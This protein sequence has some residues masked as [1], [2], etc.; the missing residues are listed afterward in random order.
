MRPSATAST[1]AEL[2]QAAR[3]GDHHAFA[4]LL[5]RYD[6]RMR[7]LAY[8]LL[9]DRSKMDDV[10][11]ESYLKAYRALGRFK[12]GSEFGTWLYK[13]TYNTCIDELRR[14]RRAPVG[15]AEIE[16]ASSRPGPERQV[17]AADQVRRALAELPPDQRLTVVLVDGEG[18]DNAT[19]AKIL[20]VA[21]GTV[22]SR[23]HRARNALRTVLAEQLGEQPPTKLQPEPAPEPATDDAVGETAS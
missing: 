23:L 3:A 19:A 15:D 16:P 10:L 11:Q 5:R 22:A 4:Q 6:D 12:D 14:S 9:A 7:G 1:D 2:I 8:K 21:P 18:F 13:I 17:T 20:G